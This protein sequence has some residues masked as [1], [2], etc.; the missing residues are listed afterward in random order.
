MK[1]QIYAEAQR[2]IAKFS[3]DEHVADVFA[4]M[5]S[6]SVP[7]Y[8]MMLEMIGI[9]ARRFARV[10]SHCYDLGCS[11]GAS[12]LAI[13]HNLPDLNCCIVAVDNSEAMVR[14][15]RENIAKDRAGNRVD[16]ICEDVM[17]TKISNA[18]LVVMN[19]TLQFIELEQR[20]ELLKT[21]FTGLNPGGVLVLS[22]KIMVEDKSE[23]TLLIDLY[24][25]FKGVQGYSDLEIAQKRDAIED[26]LVP[27]TFLKHKKRLEESGF[28][29]V[30][31]WFQCFNF[32]SLIALK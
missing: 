2:E 9:I 3:F 5:I 20:E 29:R 32:I 18:S 6:R 21:I 23:N 7:G 11:I 30:I 27:E 13:R 24:H 17:Q 19:L 16:V 22:E 31:P 26:V 12:T 10:D 25:D 1:D 28:K 14:H 8:G 15:C 4:D